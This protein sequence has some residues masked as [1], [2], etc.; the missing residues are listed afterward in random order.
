MDVTTAEPLLGD[1][2]N[3]QAGK[4]PSATGQTARANVEAIGVAIGVAATAVVLPA[5]RTPHTLVPRHHHGSR[6]PLVHQALGWVCRLPRV[7]RASGWVCRLHLHRRITTLEEVAE[8]SI[9]GG[10]VLLHHP[11]LPGRIKATKGLHPLSSIKD[12]ATSTETRGDT[13]DGVAGYGVKWVCELYA[14]PHECM[15]PI[16]DT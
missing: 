5:N 10:T 1:S 13:D 15:G 12:V 4:S 6:L 3:P 2:I 16:A 14:T 8:A 11:V 7:H 9:G